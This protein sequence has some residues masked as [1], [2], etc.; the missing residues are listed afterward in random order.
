MSMS[1]KSRDSTIGSMNIPI[2]MNEKAEDAEESRLLT[3][4]ILHPQ[5]GIPA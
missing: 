5:G 4:I 2:F 1:Q 3:G